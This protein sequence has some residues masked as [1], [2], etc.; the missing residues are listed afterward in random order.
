ML[1]NCKHCKETVD[2]VMYFYNYRIV[3]EVAYMTPIATYTA[4]V[5]GRTICPCCGS[6]IEEEFASFISNSDIRRLAV[7]EEK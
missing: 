3:T 2:V 7:M 4:V 6:K 1:I 5:N